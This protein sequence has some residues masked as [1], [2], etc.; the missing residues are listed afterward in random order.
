MKTLQR[1]AAFSMPLFVLAG[2]VGASV[3][4]ESRRPAQPAKVSSLLIVMDASVFGSDQLHGNGRNYLASMAGVLRD[5]AGN[6]PVTVVTVDPMSLDNDLGRAIIANKPSQIMRVHTVSV[7]SDRYGPVSATWQLDVEN[8]SQHP[9]ASN[10]ASAGQIT[11]ERRP[12]YRVRVSGPTC[13][14]VLAIE[15]VVRGCGAKVG[16]AFVDRLRESHVMTPNN[17]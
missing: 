12:I 5:Q 14:S 1:L 15:S 17:G 9:A 10:G 2:C 3:V 8:V 16:Q 4:D 11:V 13:S 6:I 7:Q